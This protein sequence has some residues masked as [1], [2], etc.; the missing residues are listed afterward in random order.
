MGIFIL[1][2]ADNPIPPGAEIVLLYGNF[3]FADKDLTVSVVG[4]FFLPPFEQPGS[5]ILSSATPMNW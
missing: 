5:P 4:C 3:K 1:T 2:L